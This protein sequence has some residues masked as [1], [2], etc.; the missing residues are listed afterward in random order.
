MED[1]RTRGEHD[2]PS[3]FTGCPKRNLSQQ[4]GFLPPLMAAGSKD[5]QEKFSFW[6]HPSVKSHDEVP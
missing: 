5:L 6:V 3:S 2:A 1:E 4:K